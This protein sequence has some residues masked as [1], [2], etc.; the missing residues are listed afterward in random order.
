M[1]AD[2]VVFFV[3]MA[4]TLFF[5]TH[6][7]IHYIGEKG[8]FPSLLKYAGRVFLM[9]MAVTLIANFFSPVIFYFDENGVYHTK[10]GRYL[11]LFLQILIFFSTALYM[12]AISIRTHGTAKRRHRTIGLFSLAMTALVIIQVIFPLH[13]IYTIAYLLGTCL[14]HT[15]VLEDE[16]EERR[17]ELERLLQVEKIQEKELG[18]ARLL[19]YTDPLTG[20]KSKGAYTEDV[21]GIEKRIEDGILKDFG[22]IVFDVNN[23][24][25][26]NDTKGH[27]EG[28]KLIKTACR[29]ICH[30]FKHSPVYR[31]GGDEFTVFLMGEDFKNRERLLSAFNHQIEKNKTDGSVVISC[32]CARFDE[33]HERTFK[34]LFSLADSRMYER[35]R[36]LKG[37]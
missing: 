16:K 37:M 20:V 3:A 15:F 13:P 25:T 8:R 33:I 35:K 18:S 9:F 10:N 31:I 7:V 12:L 30:S 23:L 2:T 28:D 22:I 6:Y 19:A 27:E 4:L 21:L 29:I 34:A 11:T 14:I 26:T 17:K 1:Y 36:A 5:W 32:G 24:K